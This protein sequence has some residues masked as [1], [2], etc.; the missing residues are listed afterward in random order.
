[1]EAPMQAPPNEERAAPGGGRGGSRNADWLGSSIKPLDKLRPLN[2]QGHT[3]RWNSLSLDKPL[4]RWEIP[5]D[6]LQLATTE[7]FKPGWWVQPPKS[8]QTI[9]LFTGLQSDPGRVL[10]PEE[11]DTSTKPELL[12][13]RECLADRKWWS[14]HKETCAYWAINDAFWGY[15][16][17]SS[18]PVPPDL[19]K[20][21]RL[22]KTYSLPSSP[23]R[24]RAPRGF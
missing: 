11:R 15:V 4:R 5:D 19:V 18:K 8:S 1:M 13:S 24:D 3:W 17:D 22:T 7:P 6:I 2:P 23:P 20:W 16:F 12:E 10:S 9:R 14:K 21:K